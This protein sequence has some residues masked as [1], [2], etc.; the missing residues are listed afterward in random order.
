MANSL[1][2]DLVGKTVILSSKYYKGTEEDRK[3]KCEGGFGCSNVT[4]GTAV[5]GYFVKDNEKTRIDGY[6]V[7]K[8]A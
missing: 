2:I 3:F 4:S 7:E 1:K 5:F 8:L 6:E